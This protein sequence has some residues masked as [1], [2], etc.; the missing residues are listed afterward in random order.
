MNVKKLKVFTAEVERPMKTC[1]YFSKNKTG[2]DNSNFVRI[3]PS[4][5]HDNALTFGVVRAPLE[6]MEAVMRCVYKPLL[7]K[8]EM[9]WGETSSEQKLEFLGSVDG[10]IRGLQESIRS[11]SGG[12]ELKRTDPQ[13]EHLGPQSA[14]DPYIVAQCMNLLQD[15]CVNI[16]RYL[17]DSD[18]SR[19]ENA[20]SGPDTEL[21]FWKN[22]SQRLTS[23]TE[24]LKG[25]EVKSIITLLTNVLRSHDP[26]EQIDTHR[27]N[28]LLAQWR[29]I[30]VHITEAA[31][32]AKNNVKYLSTLER[33]YE[34]LYGNSPAAI[35]DMLPALMNSIKMIHTISRYFGTNER[36]TKL[37][38]KV[39]NQMITTCKLGINGKDSYDRIW[40]KDLSVLLETIEKCL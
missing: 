20:D 31:N 14:S 15:W 22:R 11:L 35:V 17:D 37:F 29:E 39:T 12:L 2:K 34:P 38:M 16:E 8:E 6:T 9:V 21:D 24:Q 13:M 40:D 33:F 19:W 3:D 7:E 30:D 10:F 4:K 27:A 32:E 1:V 36:M 26:V 25:K 28:S 23:I 18:R 5:V